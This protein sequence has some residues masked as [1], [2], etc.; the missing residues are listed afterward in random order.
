M[1]TKHCLQV[2]TEILTAAKYRKISHAGKLVYI[3]LFQTMNKRDSDA[4]QLELL[5]AYSV[6]SLADITETRLQRCFKELQRA[7]LIVV[8]EEL[9]EVKEP[10]Q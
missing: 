2:P 9:I 8:H 6:A 4:G 5:D 1:T 10:S 7:G 3:L